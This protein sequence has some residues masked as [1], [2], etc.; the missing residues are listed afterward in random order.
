MHQ[1]CCHNKGQVAEWFGPNFT[2]SSMVIKFAATWTHN[3]YLQILYDDNMI[4]CCWVSFR[5]SVSA[6]TF[7]N[8]HVSKVRV[9]ALIIQEA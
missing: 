8:S 4:K 7:L 9:K 6:I 1:Y 3:I 5:R 2:G